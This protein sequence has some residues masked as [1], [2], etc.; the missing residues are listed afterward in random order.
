MKRVIVCLIL[1]LL[2]LNASAQE[3]AIGIRGGLNMARI[4]NYAD[5]WGCFGNVGLFGEWKKDCW[6]WEAD[7]L[8]S[9]Q[10]V[11]FDG[12]RQKDHYL[13]IPLKGKYYI[14]ACKGLNVFVGPQMDICLDRNTMLFDGGAPAESRNCMLSATFGLG[15]RFQFGLDLAANYNIG[16][17][18]NMKTSGFDPMRN[19]VFQISVGWCLYRRNK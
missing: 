6:A 11:D 17:L 9:M 1:A 13:L 15:Y 8:Y 19:S 10:G 18:S 12:Y 2:F 16:L 7:V 5:D 4:T 14:P 3:W